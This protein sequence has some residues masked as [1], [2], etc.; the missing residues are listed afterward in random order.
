MIKACALGLAALL[1]AAGGSWPTQAAE[2][3]C[4]AKLADVRRAESP[5]YVVAYRMKP[6]APKASEHFTIE[7]TVCAKAGAPLPRAVSVDARMPEHGHGMNYRADVIPRGG[8][9]FEAKGLMFHMPGR[10]EILFDVRGG[11]VSDR[12][13][14]EFRL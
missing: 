11:E 14:H 13:T 3:S 8:G 6:A 10:W 1:G 5:R 9:R 12:V 4:D 2:P 7:F